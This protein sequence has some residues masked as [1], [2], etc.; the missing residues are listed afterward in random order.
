MKM[1]NRMILAA[2]MLLGASPAG[3]FFFTGGLSQNIGNRNYQGTNAYLDIGGDLHVRP[4]YSSYHSDDSGGYTLKTYGARVGYDATIWGAGVS[5]GATPKVNGYRNNYVG[6]D[7]EVSISPTGSGPVKRITGTQQGGGEAVG[8]GLARIDFG[9]G[10][11]HIQHTD[12]LQAGGAARGTPLGIG[13]NDLKGT[14]GVSFLDNLISVDATKSYYDHNL[15]KI[16]ARPA[17]VQN[18]AGLSSTIQ[19]YPDTSANFRLEMGMMPVVKPFVGYTRT[20]FKQGAPGMGAYTAGVSVELLMVEVS[21]T[22][23][24]QV[25]KGFPSENLFGIG[26]GLRF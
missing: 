22:Y 14:V 6:A 19:G 9:V 8:K 2:V 26:A 5:A 15:D 18:L 3:A 1:N 10:A 23:Q 7:A 13:Q 20:T 11:A 4:S 17:Q 21:A 16:N 25:V 12:D 24:H